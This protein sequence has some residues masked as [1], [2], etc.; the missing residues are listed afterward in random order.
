MCLAVEPAHP[1][2]LG[3]GR[4]EVISLG[5]EAAGDSLQVR[6]SGA[7]LDVEQGAMLEVPSHDV[8]APGE[9]VVLIRLVHTHRVTATAEVR[10]LELA[11]R[12]VDQVSVQTH[13]GTSTRVDQLDP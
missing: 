10:D 7:V 3:D 12:G 1:D 11:H 8:C 9:L 6:E 2:T 4:S 13:S 5:V